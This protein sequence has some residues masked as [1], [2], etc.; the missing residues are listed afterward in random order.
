MG[1]SSLSVSEEEVV[2]TSAGLLL[3]SCPLSL[4]LE[5]DC[6]IVAIVCKWDA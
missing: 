1:P 6:T 4:A 5:K 2:S 3:F